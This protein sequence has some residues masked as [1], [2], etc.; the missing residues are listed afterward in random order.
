M[1]TDSFSCI[2][3]LLSLSCVSIFVYMGFGVLS[4]LLLAFLQDRSVSAFVLE[5]VLDVCQTLTGLAYCLVDGPTGFKHADASGGDQF[6]V[7]LSFG[8]RV[9]N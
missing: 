4:I 8:G 1:I 5:S 9:S 2:S 6:P 7:H 3:I